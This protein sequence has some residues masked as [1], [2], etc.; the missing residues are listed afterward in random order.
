MSCGRK[1]PLKHVC[2]R[3]MSKPYSIPFFCLHSS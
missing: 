1:K 2:M 3:W